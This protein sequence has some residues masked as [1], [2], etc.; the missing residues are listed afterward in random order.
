MVISCYPLFSHISSYPR[1]KKHFRTIMLIY[2]LKCSTVDPH[3]T[4]FYSYKIYDL[5]LLAFLYELALSLQIFSLAQYIGGTRDGQWA[6]LQQHKQMLPFLLST[7]AS[8]L[9]IYIS[10]FYIFLL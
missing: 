4:N 9:T 7:F 8:L 10:H 1:N 3:Y 5:L 2:E 6:V